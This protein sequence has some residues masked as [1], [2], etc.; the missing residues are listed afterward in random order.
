M[1]DVHVKSCSLF[2]HADFPTDKVWPTNRRVNGI[3]GDT[4]L[5]SSEVLEPS[6]YLI[7]IHLSLTLSPTLLP[8]KSEIVNCE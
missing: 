5:V 1:I 4:F 6:S 8:T 3:Q 7:D 2:A